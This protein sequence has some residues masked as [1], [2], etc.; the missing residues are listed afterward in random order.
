MD[1]QSEID[2]MRSINEARDDYIKFVS[3]KV[4]DKAIELLKTSKEA[5][6][7]AIKQAR[8]II[9]SNETIK[10]IIANE[11]VKQKAMAINSRDKIMTAL[12][13]VGASNI[14]A[15]VIATAIVL[16]R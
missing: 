6:S 4:T 12:L 11:M 7:V 16:T 3:E 15:V 5:D 14:V 8:T 13:L 1:R 9:S 2:G 10:A